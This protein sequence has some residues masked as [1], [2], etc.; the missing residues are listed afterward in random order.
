[1]K[2]DYFILELFLNLVES[3]I[4]IANFGRRVVT[5]VIVI[6]QWMNESFVL[7]IDTLHITL[8]QPYHCKS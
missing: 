5:D 3:L 1:M 7:F 8:Y 4:S 2:D 6:K